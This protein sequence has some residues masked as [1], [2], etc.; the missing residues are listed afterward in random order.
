MNYKN[1]K[2]RE[3]FGEAVKRK[4]KKDRKKANGKEGKEKDLNITIERI[5]AEVLD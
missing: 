1:E 5:Y 2:H 3:L 4:D